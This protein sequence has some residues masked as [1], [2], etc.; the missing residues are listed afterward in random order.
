MAKFHTKDDPCS[1][2]KNLLSF[3]H[4]D[5][6]T[7]FKNARLEFPRLHVAQSWRGEKAQTEAVGKGLSKT[8]WPK[9]A[10]N[11]TENGDPCS[12]ALDLFEIDDAGRGIWDPQTM[13][14]INAWSEKQGYRLKWGGGFK[15]FGDSGH[16]EMGHPK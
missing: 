5:M 8:P 2:C 4:P 15:S 12:R 3:A 7:W 14:K 6:G 10:H 13:A 16:F 11:W 9:S 1:G